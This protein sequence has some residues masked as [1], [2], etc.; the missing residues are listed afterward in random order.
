MIKEAIDCI[1]AGTEYCPCKLAESGECLICSQCQGECFCDCLNWKG[2]CI[3]Q[4][5][6]N[7]GNKAKDGRKAYDCTVEDVKNYNNNMIMIK[8]KAPHKLVLDLVKPGS[9]I[10]V[11]TD[12]NKYFDIPISIMNSD[13]E[14]DIITIAVEIRGIK[15]NRLLNTKTN[16]NIVIRGP[17]WNGV[18]GIKT[19]LAQKELKH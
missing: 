12:E 5:F 2:V 9:Y 19:I 11:R 6:Y 10:F 17:Y 3:Y 14:N 8:F 15:T 4:E 16:Q 7:N 18:F 1:D 13:I